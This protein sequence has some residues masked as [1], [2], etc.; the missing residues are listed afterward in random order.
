MP[1]KPNELDNYTTVAEQNCEAFRTDGWVLGQTKANGLQ[2][3][4]GLHVHKH[5]EQA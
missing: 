1:S 5:K 3:L 4:I 2:N